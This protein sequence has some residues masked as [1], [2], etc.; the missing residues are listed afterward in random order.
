VGGGECASKEGVGGAHRGR[1][2][3]VRQRKQLRA[4]AFNGSGGAPVTGGGNGVVLQH[5]GGREEARRIAIWSHDARR[6]GSPRRQKP[7]SAAAQ[8]PDGEVTGG[9]CRQAGWGDER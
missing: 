2:S 7:T 5:W 4:V 9:Q 1:R 6:G 3:T 8:N